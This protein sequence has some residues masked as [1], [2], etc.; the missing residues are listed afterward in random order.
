MTPAYCSPEQA[1]AYAKR[2]SG[3][4][5]DALPKLTRRTDIWSWAVTMLEMFVGEVCWQSGVAAPELLKQLNEVR[6]EGVEL[7]EVPDVLWQLLCDCFE[8]DTEDR[9]KSFKDVSHRLMGAHRLVME[10]D[11]AR[12]EPKTVGLRADGL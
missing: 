7:P 6:T 8:L 3:I 9:P 1:D 10:E 12:P 2:M 11:Y 4:A 5:M